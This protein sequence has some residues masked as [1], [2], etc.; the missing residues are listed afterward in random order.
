MQLNP[1]SRRQG[2]TRIPL[3]MQSPAAETRYQSQTHFTRAGHFHNVL[4]LPSSSQGLVSSL[5]SYE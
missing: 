5:Y 3:E 4:E 2:G 1:G